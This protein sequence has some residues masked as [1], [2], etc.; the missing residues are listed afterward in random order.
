MPKPN[1]PTVVI[2][3]HLSPGE[4][5]L[6][7]GRPKQGFALRGWDILFVPMSLLMVIIGSVIT[8]VEFRQLGGTGVLLFVV[9]W[10]IGSYWFAFGRFFYDARKRART[11]YALSDARVIVVSGEASY[12]IRAIQLKVL[13]EVTFTRRADDTGTLEFDRPG[14]LSYRGRFDSGRGMDWPWFSLDPLRSMAFEMIA[15]PREVYDLIVRAQ[16]HAL[17]TT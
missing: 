15:N 10:M 14:F 4:R 6:W 12:D 8:V 17:Q 3:P 13:R 2:T 5:L 9:V 11:Y 1:D 7:A 16:Q